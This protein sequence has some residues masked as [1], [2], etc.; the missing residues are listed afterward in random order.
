MKVTGQNPPRTGE[1]TQTKAREA[2]SRGKA[3]VRDAAPSQPAGTRASLTLNKVKD[4]IRNAPDVRSDKVAELRD[5]VRGGNYKVDTGRLAEK[6]INASLR[7]DI[8][9]S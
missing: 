3:S 8:E 9:R 6:M 5:Q 1:L 2:D 7:E 4:A